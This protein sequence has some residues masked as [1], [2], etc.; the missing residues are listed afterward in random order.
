MLRLAGITPSLRRCAFQRHQLFLA[1]YQIR[2]VKTSTVDWKPIHTS[3]TPDD[4]E[5][6][7]HPWARRFFLTLMCAIPVVSFYLGMWQLRRLKWK[8]ELI[9]QC[10][11]RLTY[12]PV[13]LPQKFTPEMCEDWEYRRVVVKGEFKHEEEIFVGPRVR[14]GIK[15]YLLFTPFVRKDT[16]ERLLIER[17]WVSEDRVL[18]TERGLQHLSVPRGDNVE[19]VC[20]VRKPL[21]KGRFQWDKTDDESRVWQV[22]DIPAMAAAT[23]T[24]PLHLQAIEDFHNHHWPVG[25]SDRAAANSSSSGSGPW[26]K[27]W[28]KNGGKTGP[29]GVDAPMASAAVPS[30]QS[31]SIEYNEFQ[32]M[33]EG[34]PVGKVPAVDLRNTHTQ[35]MLTWFG[36]SFFSTVLLFFA[37]RGSKGSAVSQSHLK[38]SKLKH[39][40][41]NT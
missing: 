14:N 7:N 18:P 35:Y 8:T 13:P 2:S 19:V 10:E 33:R 34:V 31:D 22:T 38:T 29:E 16:G 41:K 12:D 40:R 23:G 9:A 32:F 17:G 6:Q 27:F 25:D 21:T 1:R 24:L 28:K 11:D 30:S 3:K 26:W 5:R 4:H 20:L 39:A 15:G 37:I 36:L